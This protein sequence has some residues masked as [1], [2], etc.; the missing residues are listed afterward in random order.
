MDGRPPPSDA[1]S[2]HAKNKRLK[3]ILMCLGLLVILLLGG[4]AVATLIAVGEARKATTA[5]SLLLENQM[6]LERI[7]DENKITEKPKTTIVYYWNDDNPN[8]STISGGGA[9]PQTEGGNGIIDPIAVNNNNNEEANVFDNSNNNNDN[10]D[11]ETVV[12]NASDLDFSGIVDN[13]N[14]EGQTGNNPN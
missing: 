7:K 12:I 14:P 5:E 1:K 11:G 6:L 13:A 8:T 10:T 9:P 2:L 3:F 4:L